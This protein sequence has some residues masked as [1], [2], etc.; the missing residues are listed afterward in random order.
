MTELKAF[1]IPLSEIRRI[2]KDFQLEMDRGLSGRKSS[3]KM[4]PTYVSR[5]NGREKGKFIALD[6]G[7]TNF[8]ILRLTLLGAGRIGAINVMKFVLAKKHMTG[9]AEGFFGFIADSVKTFLKKYRL[10]SENELDMGFTF[11]FP[12][13]QT[14]AA[15]GSLV[16][17]T[18]DFDVSG[19]IGNDVVGLLNDALAKIGVRNVNISALA[20]DTVGTL[21]AK[22]YE[23]ETCDVGVIIGTGTNACYPE[24]R[25]G[26]MILNIEWG[27]FNK[28]KST[29]Y[30]RALDRNSDNPGEQILEKMVSGMYLGRLAGLL[31]GEKFR[32]KDEF[33]T[34]HMSIIESDGSKDLSRTGLILKKIGVRN[35]SFGDRQHVKEIC[36][37]V[38]RRGARISAACIAAIV[39]KMD[40]PLSGNHTVA[41]DGSVYEKHPTFAKSMKA[42]LK[43]IFGRRSSR[44]RMALVKDGSG[45]GAAI[46][47]AAAASR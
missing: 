16:C 27:N 2:I 15:S 11:S 26:G 14:G 23:D 30:D 12:V 46:I 31:L 36:Q 25:A 10:E 3:L 42:A 33:K 20:N 17:W 29:P 22:S 13:R 39:K 47:A 34:E 40:P 44:V 5:P 4:I 21:V 6:F 37:A 7:G 1:D 24:A 19:V 32:L 41:I 43:E 8:R 9:S 35:S 18:K 45:K 28:L 38:S